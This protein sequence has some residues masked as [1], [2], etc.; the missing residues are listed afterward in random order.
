LNYI[1]TRDAIF[2][3]A[4]KCALSGKPTQ[5]SSALLSKADAERAFDEWK[6]EHPNLR[7]RVTLTFT[8]SADGIPTAAFAAKS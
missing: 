3:A 2:S 1:N 7:D 8:A 4:A 5:T 6:T